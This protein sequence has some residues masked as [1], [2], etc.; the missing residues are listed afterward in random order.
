MI[1]LNQNKRRS[2]LPE[3]RDKISYRG[4]FSLHLY[5]LLRTI[6][7]SKQT[8]AIR[9]YMES[10][11]G[12]IYFD[13]GKLVHAESAGLSGE[14]AFKTIVLM[15]DGLYEKI[16]D[17]CADVVSIER[18]TKVLLD[19]TKGAMEQGEEKKYV[20]TLVEEIETDEDRKVKEGLGLPLEEGEEEIEESIENQETDSAEV[21]KQHNASESWQSSHVE[22]A[23]RGFQEELWMTDWGHNT[24][25]FIA[26]RI[27]R[28]DGVSIMRA[29]DA[30]EELSPVV[31][32]NVIDAAKQ[33]AGDLVELLMESA[34]RLY[35]I[36]HLADGYYLV[37]AL[38]RAKADLATLE[39]RLTPLIK[40][41][42]ESLELA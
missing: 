42:K 11:E 1:K 36:S 18:D 5:N 3:V 39:E 30:R 25:G 33:F 6:R 21:K 28:E 12:T 29:L 22:L 17:L 24:P 19:E 7:R 9:V 8:V 38:D 4:P 13:K 34:T 20:L 32:K 40:V 31:T 35:S 16:P 10:G 26:A 41:L 14:E 23:G 15:R 37:L 2:I 27:V